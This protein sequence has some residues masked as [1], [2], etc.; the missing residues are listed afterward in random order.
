[1]R[2]N[3]SKLPTVLHIMELSDQVLRV[4]SISEMTVITTVA[5]FT[6][7]RTTVVP[8][9]LDTGFDLES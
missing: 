3:P 9:S 6:C 4:R 7:A 5:M 1:M 2:L 8:L